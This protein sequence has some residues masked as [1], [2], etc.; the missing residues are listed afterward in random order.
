MT[1]VKKQIRQRSGAINQA[2]FKRK[3]KTL[4]ARAAAKPISSRTEN[5]PILHAAEWLTQRTVK[6]IRGLKSH[7]DLE[8]DWA[9][10]IARLNEVY[11]HL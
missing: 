7:L 6:F 8:R 9:Q 1:L 10:T 4:A 11:S 5:R 2:E 3:A